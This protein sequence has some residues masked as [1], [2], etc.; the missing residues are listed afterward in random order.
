MGDYFLGPEVGS[1]VWWR[2]AFDDDV[3]ARRREQ[4]RGWDDLSISVFKLL[5]MVVAAWIFVTQ[6]NV[7]TSY[8]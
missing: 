2:F 8:A 1:G 3:R 4:V 7:R 6:L 5:G